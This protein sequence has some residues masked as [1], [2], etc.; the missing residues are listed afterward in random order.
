MRNSC[1]TGSCQES[2]PQPQHR[3]R[4]SRRTPPPSNKEKIFWRDF[5]F[6]NDQQ[7]DDDNCHKARIYYDLPLLVDGECADL[8]TLYYDLL[9]RQCLSVITR[10]EPKHQTEYTEK[11]CQES[12][13]DYLNVFTQLI[14]NHTTVSQEDSVQHLQNSILTLEIAKDFYGKN[15]VDLNNTGF[16][17]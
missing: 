10:E 5:P 13:H 6:N 16:N 12:C 14:A 7:E 4:H 15:I 9:P 3:R 8:S 11:K 2:T 17:F 1:A